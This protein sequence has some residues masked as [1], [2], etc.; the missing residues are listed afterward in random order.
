MVDCL[1][2]GTPTRNQKYCSLSCANSVNSSLRSYSDPVKVPCQECGQITT[3]PMFCSRSCAV[4]VTNRSRKRGELL[5]QCGRRLKQ[6]SPASICQSCQEAD[7]LQKWLR[8]EIAADSTSPNKPLAFWARRYL[9]DAANHK[10]TQCGWGQPHPDDGKV[11]LNIDHIDGNRYNNL[12]VN[13]RV[14]CPNCHSLTPTYCGRNRGNSPADGSRWT[15]TD[16]VS[17]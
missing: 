9:L 4:K 14:L 6:K 2:C 15:R 11:P 1:K 17:Q 16:F 7:R 10:C 13:L 3:N 8:G 12:F 5:C